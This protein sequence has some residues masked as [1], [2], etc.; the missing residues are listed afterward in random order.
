MHPTRD[1][2]DK[3]E[4]E[5]QNMCEEGVRLHLVAYNFRVDMNTDAHLCGPP[6]TSW[7]TAVIA[8]VFS[9][10]DKWLPYVRIPNSN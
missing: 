4:E 2:S 8:S 6:L 9:S 1:F 10:R 3:N 7:T 5:K